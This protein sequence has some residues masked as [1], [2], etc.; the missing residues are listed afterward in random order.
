MN[1][2][3]AVIIVAEEKAKKKEEEEEANLDQGREE[4]GV[5]D[6]YP[7]PQVC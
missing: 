4:E 1:I 2:N 7:N 3:I 5:V 6:F